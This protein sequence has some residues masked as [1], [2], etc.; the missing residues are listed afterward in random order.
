MGRAHE[1]RRCVH[2]NRKSC[3]GGHIRNS[4]KDQYHDNEGLEGTMCNVREYANEIF[5][6]TLAVGALLTLAAVIP[7]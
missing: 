5:A 3:D 1:N 2:T 4:A 7:A 6:L